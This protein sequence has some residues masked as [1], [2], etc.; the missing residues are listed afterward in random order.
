MKIRQG[1]VSNSSS[2]SYIIGIAKVIDID[3]VKLIIEDSWG[4]EII[5]VVSDEDKIVESFDYNSVSIDDLEIGDIVLHIKRF[6]DEG[7]HHFD[8]DGD[9][10]IDYEINYDDCDTATIKIIEKLEKSDAIGDINLTWG[11]GRNG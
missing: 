2:S 7:D 3:A 10:Y 5:D 9:G 11:A 8:P 1:F 6:G 4:F